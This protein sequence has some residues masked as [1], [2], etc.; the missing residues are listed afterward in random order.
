MCLYCNSIV[1]A[2]D[3]AGG[4]SLA[5]F[6]SLLHQ[7]LSD[8]YKRDAVSQYVNREGSNVLKMGV[9]LY[10]YMNPPVLELF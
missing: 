6:F 9:I 4:A 8:H 5:L 2:K 3:C 10:V 1:A 7:L